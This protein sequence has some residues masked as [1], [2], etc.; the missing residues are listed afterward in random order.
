MAIACRMAHVLGGTHPIARIGVKGH[1]TASA[2]FAPPGNTLLIGAHPAFDDPI[3]P[4]M[5]RE[6]CFI[7][8][9][10][11]GLE[12]TGVIV[13]SDQRERLTLAVE[14]VQIEQCIVRGKERAQH[15]ANP[16]FEILRYRSRPQVSIQIAIAGSGDKLIRERI[17]D[18]NQRE[19]APQNSQFACIQFCDQ[20]LDRPNA[21]KFIAVYGTQ[22]D[23]PG[24]GLQAM[25]LMNAKRVL[26]MGLSH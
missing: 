7:C 16:V 26:K 1:A 6:F 4:E 3:G 14:G 25:K 15:I 13:G 11:K 5:T 24:P 20:P 22:H 23:Q 18:G 21:S 12:R 17:G 8:R 19:T 10:G 2:P 9:L